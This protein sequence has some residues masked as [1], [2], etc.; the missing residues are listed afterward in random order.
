[1]PSPTAMPPALY[2]LAYTARCEHAIDPE[3]AVQVQRHPT[4]PGARGHV[5]G[6]WLSARRAIAR[7]IATPYVASNNPSGSATIL[8]ARGA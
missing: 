4:A 8:T 7:N 5:A 6:D 1:M 3:R 2:V